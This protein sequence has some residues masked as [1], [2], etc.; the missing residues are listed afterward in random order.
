MK[1][2]DK[3]EYAQL[4]FT[5][6]P[7]ILM[8]DIAAKVGVTPNTVTSWR[9]KDNWDK[10]RETIQKTR[11]EQ[12][13]NLYQELEALNNA[14]REREEAPYATKAEADTRTQITRSISN[15]EREM[16]AAQVVAVFNPFLDWLSDVDPAK[17][18]LVVELQDA[19]IKSSF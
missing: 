9:R 18:K 1:S 14:I 11:H 2:T 7:R 12:L 10:H 15:L 19:Y 6:N 13:R 3:R 16:T 4:L 8:K 5:Q 17:A